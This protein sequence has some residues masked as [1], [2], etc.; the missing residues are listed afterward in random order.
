M[1]E[2]S[3]RL[4]DLLGDSVNS[5]SNP[6]VSSSTTDLSC[7]SNRGTCQ[8]LMVGQQFWDL[9]EGEEFSVYTKFAKCVSNFPQFNKYVALILGNPNAVRLLQ[10]YNSGLVEISKYL[11]PKLLLGS[12]YHVLYLTETVDYLHH[13]ATDDEDK[14][15]LK[16]TLDT[17]KKIRYE[18]SSTGD[19]SHFSF[20]PI[21]TSLRLSYGHQFIQQCDKNLI[22]WADGSNVSSVFSLASSG[23]TATMTS[24]AISGQK[25]YN[26]SQALV[27]NM[28]VLTQRKKSELE[29]R[30]ESFKW[31]AYINQPLVQ[32]ST[33]PMQNET[34]VRNPYLF[35][36]KCSTFKYIYEF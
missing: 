4:A 28:A 1:Y 18:L 32:L 11:L 36:S 31:P 30:V 34:T 7:P 6:L 15:C 13:C 21:E 25:L 9:A 2:C 20:K 33:T 26:T 10:Q 3:L 14:A 22:S 12:I 29:N 23:S 5:K 8:S 19:Y 35:E 17:L 27:A 16:V 24:N